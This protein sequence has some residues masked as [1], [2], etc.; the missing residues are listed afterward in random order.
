MPGRGTDPLPP[1]SPLLTTGQCL[2]A[3]ILLPTGPKCI[4]HRKAPRR[5]QLSAP[6]GSCL[7]LAVSLVMPPVFLAA[8]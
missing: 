1:L 5:R 8:S 2:R 7:P 6:W 4:L 3:R